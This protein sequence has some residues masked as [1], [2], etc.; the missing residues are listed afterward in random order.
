MRRMARVDNK[1]AAAR[2]ASMQP[3]SADNKLAAP[4]G[5]SNSGD[6]CSGT[7]E[8]PARRVGAALGAAATD[9][10]TRTWPARSGFSPSCMPFATHGSRVMEVQMGLW[11]IAM[12]LKAAAEHQPPQLDTEITISILNTGLEAELAAK[13]EGAVKT[14]E[15]SHERR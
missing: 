15:A 2:G 10:Q 9:E 1:P 12:A 4:A 8:S 14:P 5:R 11:T 7:A 6:E 3:F 13:V